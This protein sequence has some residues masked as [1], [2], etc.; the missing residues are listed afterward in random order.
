MYFLHLFF[1]VVFLLLL[2]IREVFSLSCDRE[3][4]TGFVLFSV[5]NI[6]DCY[7][8]EKLPKGPLFQL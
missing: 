2:I 1:R 8:Q 6:C 5:K 7:S 4:E 3:R